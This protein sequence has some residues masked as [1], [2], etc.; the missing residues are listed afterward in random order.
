MDTE[1][2][3]TVRLIS[4]R[5]GAKKISCTK[6]IQAYTNMGLKDAKCAVDDCLEEKETAFKMTSQKEAQDFANSL[7][8][9]GFITTIEKSSVEQVNPADRWRGR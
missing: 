5:E 9:I 2:I 8:D 6:T 4:W 7:E 3:Y 1:K